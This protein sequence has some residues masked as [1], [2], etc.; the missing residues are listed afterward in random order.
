MSE[1]GE[2]A[3]PRGSQRRRRPGRAT[4]AA[5]AALVAA[6]ATAAAAAAAGDGA[7]TTAA[8]GHAGDASAAESGRAVEPAVHT[9]AF[10]ISRGLTGPPGPASSGPAA[11]SDA[12]GAGYVV[13]AGTTL[14]RVP[15]SVRLL[16]SLAHGDIVCSLAL[17]RASR[18]V[19]TGGRGVIKWWDV[20]S[21]NG[22]LLADLPC[23]P[24]SYIRSCRLSSDETMLVAGGEANSICIWDLAGAGPRAKALLPLHAPACYALALSANN[25]LC[26][27]CG[28]DGRISVWDV[29]N[30]Q[31]LYTYIGHT[32]GVSCAELTPDGAQLVTGS[33]DNTAK[34]RRPRCC[35]VSRG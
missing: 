23:L 12:F 2:D 6:S 30:Q 15:R 9:A 32:D 19:F 26:F 27:S 17:S 24:G 35:P 14:G 1:S 13:A 10:A 3:E 21:G 29:H 28:S 4:V 33:L 31:L 16:T 7:E 5:A 11:G 8:S 20:Q 34:V 22:Q 25:Q 18:S